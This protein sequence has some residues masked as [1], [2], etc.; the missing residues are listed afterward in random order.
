MPFDISNDETSAGALGLAL[1]FTIPANLAGTPTI[2]VPCSFSE[3]GVPYSLQLVAAHL[4]EA[5]LCQVAHA[6]EQATDWHTRHPDV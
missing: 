2:T 6:Y 3:A 4:N 5:A 1:R